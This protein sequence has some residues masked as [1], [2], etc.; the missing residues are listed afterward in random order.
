[1]KVEG[2]IAISLVKISPLRGLSKNCEKLGESRMKQV[3]LND[4]P[5]DL[6]VQGS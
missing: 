5:L 1:M 4:M 2:N 6:S 3:S